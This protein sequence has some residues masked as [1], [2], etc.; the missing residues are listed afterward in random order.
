VAIILPFGV[1]DVLSSAL[2][3]Q[4]WMLWTG[5]V[6][7]VQHTQNVAL[8]EVIAFLPEPMLI[9]LLVAL[10]KTRHYPRGTNV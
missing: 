6:G 1:L 5:A 7:F 3:V 9:W 8:G 4:P 2:G 10:V